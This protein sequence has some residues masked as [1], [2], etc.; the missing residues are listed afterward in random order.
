MIG[1][2]AF[3]QPLIR[4]G[5]FFTCLSA[6]TAASIAGE[7]TATELIKAQDDLLRGDTVHGSYVMTVVTPGWKRSLELDVWGQGRDKMFI[8]ILSPAKE[9]GIGTLRIDSNMW[10]YMP[11]IE[12]TIKIPPS[13]MLQPWMGSDFSNDDLVKESSIVNDYTH[14]FIEELVLDGHPARRIRLDPKPGAAVTWGKLIF[15]VRTDG[16]IPLREEYYSEKGQ[17]IKAL[18]FSKPRQMNDRVI[19]TLW[20]MVNKK[21]DGHKTIIEIVDAVYN[22]PVD[23]NIFTL[24]NLSRVWE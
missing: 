8:R 20:T 3:I 24:S 4:S 11:K 7:L 6:F 15:L 10:N 21:K 5:L 12:R 18:D 16:H 2:R 9:K 19:P 22:E 23:E 17:L 14:T 1:V 13:M